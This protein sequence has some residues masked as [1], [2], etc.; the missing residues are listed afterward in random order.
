M[1]FEMISDIIFWC[2]ANVRFCYVVSTL[3]F[4][5]LFLNEEGCEDI[6]LC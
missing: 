2:L 5:H 1:K 6:T 4:V 3:W